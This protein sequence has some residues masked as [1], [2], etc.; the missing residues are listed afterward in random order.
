[1]NPL[2]ASKIPQ[3]RASLDLLCFPQD[4]LMVA[5]CS[6]LQRN[7]CQRNLGTHTL[8]KASVNSVLSVRMLR[9]QIHWWEAGHQRSMEK[10]CVLDFNEKTTF[11]LLRGPDPLRHKSS[12]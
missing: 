11:T 8:G 9:G 12:L 2:R 6:D 10:I 3:S 7:A 4:V 1:M 5:S